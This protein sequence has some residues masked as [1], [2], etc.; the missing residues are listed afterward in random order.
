MIFINSIQSQCQVQT[1]KNLLT[2][3]RLN[4]TNLFTSLFFRTLFVGWAAS[5]TPTRSITEKRKPGKKATHMTSIKICWIDRERDFDSPSWNIHVGDNFCGFHAHLITKTILF[6][7]SLLAKRKKA[8]AFFFF[9]NEN[10]GKPPFILLAWEGKKKK[11]KSTQK[12]KHR[13]KTRPIVVGNK[14]QRWKVGE[15]KSADLDRQRHQSTG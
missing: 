15:D 1:K 7:I 2:T 5:A 13:K 8:R 6:S 4:K 14:M 11:R 3:I 12:R 9:S 10:L